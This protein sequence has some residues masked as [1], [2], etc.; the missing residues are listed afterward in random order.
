MVDYLFE[1]RRNRVTITKEDKQKAIGRFQRDHKDTGSSEVQIAVLTRRIQ[2]LTDHLKTHKKDMHTKR[3]LLGLV[4]KRKKLI[5]YLKR[6]HPDIHRKT[7]KEL[8]LRK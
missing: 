3:G 8:G 2:N 4:S 1:C 5:K 6:T 7:L